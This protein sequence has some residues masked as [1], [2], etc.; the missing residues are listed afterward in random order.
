MKVKINFEGEY[1]LKKT[2]LFTP[3]IVLSLLILST[4]A[5]FAEATKPK[6]LENYQKHHD[7][8][9][10]QKIESEKYND[11]ERQTVENFLKTAVEKCDFSMNTHIELIENIMKEDR[12]KSS[13][14]RFWDLCKDS[15]YDE[16]CLSRRW[17]TPEFFHINIDQ[18]EGK[19]YEKYGYL[20]CKNKQ[21]KNFKQATGNMSEWYGNVI[22][23]FK[24]DKLID[25]TT[26]TI[27]D[28]LN[29]RW[30]F[31]KNSI[32]PTMAKDPKIVCV[33]GYFKNLVS[34]LASKINEGKLLPQ[35]PNSISEIK[36]LDA[37]LDY[38]E[39]Q[40][41]GDLSFK[42]DVESVDIIRTKAHSESEKREQERIAAKIK[43][44]GIPANII[45]CS[46]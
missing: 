21:S 10:M 7:S 20:T 2:K 37:S 23:N 14:E 13:M 34:L 45:D 19:D 32:T 1:K 9:Y 8:V 42:N 35:Y 36:Y 41:H 40:F 17:S 27:G 18:L 15:E 38:F 4:L 30:H 39:L 29:N 11:L 16:K 25:K 28:S 26:L 3:F 5:G 46:E 6:L 43:Q 12:I 33:P 22:M 24:K 44:L 31:G